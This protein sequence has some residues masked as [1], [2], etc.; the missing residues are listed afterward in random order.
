MRKV[1]KYCKAD[2]HKRW[3]WWEAKYDM[4]TW[5]WKPLGEFC[6]NCGKQ[7]FDTVAAGKAPMYDKQ[8]GWSVS[9]YKRNRMKRFMRAY[10]RAA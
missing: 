3:R 9:M 8:I 2:N 4:S 7:V 5:R 1:D 6:C 10:K